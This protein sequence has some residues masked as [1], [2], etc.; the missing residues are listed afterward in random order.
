MAQ[1][2]P[3]MEPPGLTVR[4]KWNKVEGYDYG[5]GGRYGKKLFGRTYAR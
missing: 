1:W 3:L 4:K 5:F 2:I